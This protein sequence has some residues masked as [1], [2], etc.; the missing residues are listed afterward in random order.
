MQRMEIVSWSVVKEN[1]LIFKDYKNHSTYSE[2]LILPHT[3]GYEQS[4][5]LF[6]RSLMILSFERSKTLWYLD[7]HQTLITSYWRIV[8]NPS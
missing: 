4:E 6:D 5:I 7:H 2:Q 3:Q 8:N 1:V